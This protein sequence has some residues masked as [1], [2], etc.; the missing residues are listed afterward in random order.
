[1]KQPDPRT[2]G[3]SCCATYTHLRRASSPEAWVLGHGRGRGRGGRG[4]GNGSGSRRRR[5]G[6]RRRRRS[7]VGLHL[8]FQRSCFPHHFVDDAHFFFKP[9]RF[10]GVLAFR[11]VLSRWGPASA[12]LCSVESRWEVIAVVG[13]VDVVVV[14]VLRA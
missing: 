12:D 8:A 14:W 4:S 3:R 5:H 10:A 11:L 2:H 13:V 1:M 6:R 9:F 7:S